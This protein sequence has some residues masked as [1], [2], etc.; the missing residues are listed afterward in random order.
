MPE[1]TPKQSGHRAG[2]SI[3]RIVIDEC[4]G[5][6]SPLLAQLTGRLRGH[7]VELV[8]LAVR[9]P[10][11]PDVEILDKLLDGRT[12]LLTQDRALHNLT[13][14]RGFRSF[15]QSPDGSLTSRK[16]HE[17]ATRDK[18]L[19]AAR[20]GLRDSYVH[21]RARDAQVIAGSLAGF[22]S[23]HQLKQFRT[24]RRRIRAHFGSADNIAANALT[25]GQ[26]R[27]PRGIVGGYVLKVDARHGAKSLSPASEGY[28]LDPTGGSALQAL[29][30][31]LAHVLM[32]Q[33]EQ[34]P[35]TLF[36]C[37]SDV[38]ETCAALIAGRNTGR[39][40]VERMAVRLLATAKQPQAQACVKGGF[41]DRMQAKLDQ[42]TAHDSNE[43]V[44]IDLQAMAD[45]LEL[46]NAVGDDFQ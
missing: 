16:L 21:E 4:F 13:I 36:L 41:F 45:A 11:I 3:E 19:P 26:R 20:G 28:F 18:S 33:L 29:V 43:L 38:A 40:S 27:T 6:D 9:H 32:L 5:P 2:L 12:A 23:E 34:R 25:I 7:P 39:T 1:H 17:V 10:G 42:L 15:V 30:W 8:F 46:S 37:D 35:L 44:A 22:L 24:K 14:D 31:G